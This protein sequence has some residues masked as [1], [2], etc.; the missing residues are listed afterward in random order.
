[1]VSKASEAS[2]ATTGKAVKKAADV[3]NKKEMPLEEKAR[4]YA[5]TLLDFAIMAPI[6]IVTRVWAQD[7]ADRAFGAPQLPMKN[8]LYAKIP[9]MVANNVALVAMNT[10]AKA[11]SQAL[12]NMTEKI[13]CGVGVDPTSADS[14]AKYLV[15][16]QG[17]NF[18]G[19]FANV[20]YVTAVSRKL[21]EAASPQPQGR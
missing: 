6:G 3:F 12:T 11:P 18:I 9:D 13:L 21:Q 4:K 1:M 17:S 20:G 15:Y 7:Y 14:M 19:N 10:V 2:G 8:Y 5:D 16:V